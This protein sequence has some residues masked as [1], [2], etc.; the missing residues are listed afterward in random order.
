METAAAPTTEQETT[1]PTTTLEVDEEQ[2]ESVVEEEEEDVMDEQE[3]EEEE[4]QQQ[5]QQQHTSAEP[6]KSESNIV[7]TPVAAP[8]AN[9][10]EAAPPPPPTTTTT[11]ESAAAAPPPPPLP[12]PRN[13]HTTAS[14]SSNSSTPRFS[15][16]NGNGNQHQH[17]QQQR[18]ARHERRASAVRPSTSSEDGRDEHRR[19]VSM[20]IVA[21]R[22]GASLLKYGRR[23][24]PHVCHFRLADG[25]L[26]LQW[27]SHKNN[28]ETRSVRLSTV[29][30]V[31][32]GQDTEKFRRFPDF[33]AA[34]RSFSLVY[35]QANDGKLTTLD[36]VCADA[37]EFETWCAGLLHVVLAWNPAAR[38]VTQ[39]P[40]AHGDVSAAGAS[41]PAP[42]PAPAHAAPPSLR[43]TTLPPTV[44]SASGDLFAWGT[45]P[46]GLVGAAAANLTA[47]ND[48][49]PPPQPPP[50]SSPPPPA[51]Q[52]ASTMVAYPLPQRVL[53]AAFI[54]ACAVSAGED[55]ACLVS[56][57]G[58]LYCWGKGDDGR[59][60]H[61]SG[62]D[63]W[64]PTAVQDCSV[65]GESPISDDAIGAQASCG[66]A[67]TA[68]VN[69]DGALFTWGSPGGAGALGDGSLHAPNAF[70]PAAVPLPLND[71]HLGV[72]MSIACGPYHSAAVTVSGLLLTWGDG[73]FGKLGHASLA[74]ECTPRVVAALPATI[75]CVACGPFHTAAVDADGNLFTWG[76]ADKN[77]LG[78]GDRI[79]KGTAYVSEPYEVDREAFGGEAI[80]S[81]SCGMHH[82]TVL[83]TAGNV[84]ECGRTCVDAGPKFLSM[85]RGD[86]APQ[87]ARRVALVRCGD[88][89]SV[90]VGTNGAGI[91]TWGQGK[92]GALG[93][94]EPLSWGAP[95]EVAA[96]QG[97]AVRDVACL[98]KG[99]LAIVEMEGWP[100]ELG[101]EYRPRKRGSV[102]SNGRRMSNSNTTSVTADHARGSPKPALSNGVVSSHA[103]PNPRGN[104]GGTVW[105]F[106]MPGDGN[107][108]LRDRLLAAERRNAEL[109]QQLKE[110]KRARSA[111]REVATA[112][113]VSGEVASPAHPESSDHFENGPTPSPRT[114]PRQI[115]ATA[116]PEQG[117]SW[118]VEELRARVHQL[119]EQLRIGALAL[120][121]VEDKVVNAS[122]QP[123]SAAKA[124]KASAEPDVWRSNPSAYT[125]EMS[126]NL[127]P[128]G[129]SINSM[130]EEG[131]EWVQECE[132]GVYAVLKLVNG[133]RQ[134]LR[135]RFSKRYFSTAQAETHWRQY[136]RALLSKLDVDI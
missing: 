75:S 43:P 44:N 27:I 46:V 30:E 108:H 109:E 135:L 84:F 12:P 19:L 91:F 77:A 23:G 50:P 83:T 5:Q 88:D 10:D 25:D 78:L 120:S 118:E 31:R 35:P 89:H 61:G 49:T 18:Q 119:T 37:T 133:R 102:F 114:A 54:D 2:V 58:A 95:K 48:A 68:A 105:D 14:T 4:T 76:A 110:I 92:H 97:R 81:A 79:A 82:T 98:A 123:K 34:D 130:R 111:S 11:T 21:L 71:P 16:G 53:A 1:T 9:V 20:S 80:S 28:H 7:W 59:L 132:A 90:A 99:T 125:P 69:T 22:K 128:M 36:V 122:P 116:T 73:S 107:A 60:G 101:Q 136:G 26:D 127:S 8:S 62:N 113:A 41:A 29:V 104:G 115:A 93:H 72:V 55:H 33:A 103:I 51:A 117:V 129:N 24:K 52:S 96:L 112:V 126:R 66:H 124:I 39:F 70:A 131:E 42:A 38:N 15:I 74:T 6:R 106:G 94:G 45:L 40:S 63:A 32:S 57:D 86:L 56:S 67:H 100:T 13:S 47:T 121:S 64:A 85:M 17:V 3:E 65:S 87:H 134:L